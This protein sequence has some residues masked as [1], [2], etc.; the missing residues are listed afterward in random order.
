MGCGMNEAIFRGYFCVF[1][2]IIP[3]GNNKK[4]NLVCDLASDVGKDVLLLG[5]DANGNWIRTDQGG[6]ILDGELVPLAQG[7][8]TTSTNFFSS[9]TGVQL[10][11]AR[12]GQVWAYEYDTD[13]TTKRMI[14]Q[15]Q[16]FET[17]PDYARYYFPGIQTGSAVSN[18]GSCTQTLVEAI[19]K[20]NFWP[21]KVATDYLCVPC[22]PA[23][24]EMLQALNDAENEPDG[25]KKKQL[26]AAGVISARA[27]L[28]K[29]LQHFTGDGN[30][31]TMSVT[32]SAPYTDPIYAPI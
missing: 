17:N 19:V 28:D 25:I 24:K 20:L 11:V 31:I 14:G 3:T 13:T 10:N 26:I 23:L 4:V 9:L 30:E 5:Y 16:S 2:D 29:Q 21:V 18:N 27:I 32:G 7:A 8:G 1:A 22:I 15:Y 12:D 6:T